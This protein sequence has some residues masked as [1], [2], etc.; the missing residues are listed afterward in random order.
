MLIDL[1]CSAAI[2]ITCAVQTCGGPPGDQKYMQQYI[3]KPLE[4]TPM[5]NELKWLLKEGSG[6]IFKSC[7]ISPSKIRP[8]HV[9]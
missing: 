5:G 2:E 3:L 6:H 7:N 1:A 9:S 8:P 4:N